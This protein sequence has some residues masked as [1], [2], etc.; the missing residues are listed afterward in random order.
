MGITTHRD[1]VRRQ[2]PV[3]DI[4]NKHHYDSGQRTP[5]QDTVED[6]FQKRINHSGIV[7][8]YL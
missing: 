6:K 4:D 3:Q 8:Y 7:K 1:A 5:A 2:R